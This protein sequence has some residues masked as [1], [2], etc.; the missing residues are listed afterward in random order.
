AV[1]VEHRAAAGGGVVARLGRRDGVVGGGH[2]LG[3]LAALDHAHV[4][5]PVRQARRLDQAARDLD[6]E[7]VHAAVEPEAQDAAELLVDLRVVPVEVGLAA[8]EEVQVPLAVVLPGAAGGV[9]A[10]AHAGPG[11]ATEHRLPVVRR[12]LPV[13]TPALAEDVPRAGGG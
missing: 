7:A 11:G 5:R 9:G 6:A 8:V 13:L 2:A 3:D 10:V 1:L 12:L 4:A